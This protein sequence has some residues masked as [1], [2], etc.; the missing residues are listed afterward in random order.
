[1]EGAPSL[2]LALSVFG[3]ARAGEGG[4][5]NCV[6]DRGREEEL[7]ALGR[8]HLVADVREDGQGD[9]LSLW[10]LCWCPFPGVVKD[11]LE[12]GN[13]DALALQRG[14]VGEEAGVVET[15]VNGGGGR[16]PDVALDGFDVGLRGSF[17]AA[18]FG[19]LLRVRREDLARLR[20][21]RVGEGE[22][23]EAAM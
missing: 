8:R 21:R 15:R 11:S 4:D 12:E 7:G 1:M 5:D 18:A 10:A 19:Y 2:W 13:K 23:V 6:S 14:D 17:D 22:V 3:D 20:R 16:S 9:R